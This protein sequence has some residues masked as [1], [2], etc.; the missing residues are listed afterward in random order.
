MNK[1]AKD[2]IMAEHY[3]VEYDER[4]STLEAEVKHVNVSVDSLARSVS[5]LVS[6]IRGELKEIREAGKITWPLIFT[7]IGTLVTCGTIAAA[8]HYQ[9]LQPI[10]LIQEQT[11]RMSSKENEYILQRI[12]LEKQL[13]DIRF[14]LSQTVDNN[15]LDALERHHESLEQ[16]VQDHHVSVSAVNAAQNEQIQT[17]MQDKQ[18]ATVLIR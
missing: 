6:E 12:E 14:T 7:A 4:L 5:N 11:N 2:K 10:Y 1:I 3:D 18:N 15:R 8:L 17:L 16:T 9:S 13:V